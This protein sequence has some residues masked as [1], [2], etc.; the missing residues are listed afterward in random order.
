MCA[1]NAL[2]I[3]FIGRILVVCR[4][5]A[6]LIYAMRYVIYYLKYINSLS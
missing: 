3:K 4:S 2:I 6:A 1:I 5:Q